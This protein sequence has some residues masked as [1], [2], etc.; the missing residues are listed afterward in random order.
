MSGCT[1]GALLSGSLRTILED[2]GDD[3]RQDRAAGVFD[4]VEFALSGGSLSELARV[5][6]GLTSDPVVGVKT[7]EQ[8]DAARVILAI[9]PLS[10]ELAERYDD[11]GLIIGGYRWGSDALNSILYHA[12]LRSIW[13]SIG[14]VLAMILLKLVR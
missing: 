10:F 12:A 11:Q 8:P 3:F 5:A 7:V 1:I 13:F 4:P 9:G 6:P 2:M 14:A